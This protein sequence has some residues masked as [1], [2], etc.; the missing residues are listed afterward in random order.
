MTRKE[1]LET[2]KPVIIPGGTD[3]IQA[4]LEGRKTVFRKPVMPQPDEKHQYPLGFVKDSTEKKDIGSFGFGVDELG[5]SIQYARPK[6]RPD[7]VLYLRETWHTYQ[8]RVGK[9]EGCLIGEFYGYKASIANSEDADEPWN[10]PACMP[11]EAAR[12][13]LR[14]KDV[15]VERLQN[16]TEVDTAKEGIRTDI[17]TNRLDDPNFIENFGGI[18]LFKDLWDSDVK[19]SVLTR[20]E[21]D[22]N[23]WVFVYEFE[24]VPVE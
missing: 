19:K 22:A 16:M 4:I 10:S 8:K 3:M 5:G 15:R 14:I 7:D 2:A 9:G 23:P 18:E 20:Y 6:Y 24:L 11:K 17:Q 12:I 21:W 1:L 13:F